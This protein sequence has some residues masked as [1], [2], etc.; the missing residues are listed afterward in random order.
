M[1]SFVAPDAW[2]AIDFISDLHLS[3]A[4]PRTFDAW[5][6]FMGGT[7]ADAVF[8]LGDLFE[9]WVGDDSRHDPFE[10]R[11]AQVL[12]DAARRRAVAF[13]AGNRDFLVGEAL[14]GEC[15]VAALPDPTLLVACGQRVVLT[16]GDA[17]CL[18]DRDY[19]RYRAQV[20]SPQWQRGVLALPLPQ[21]RELARRM[22]DA[23]TQAQRALAR[24]EWADV[25]PD[26]AVALLRE[27][28]AVE[29]VHG[30]THRPGSG[31]LAPGFTRHVLSDW[32]LDATPPRAQVLRLTGEGFVR[33]PWRHDAAS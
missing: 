31:L 21:R 23:T 6:A 17:L 26:A 16:H 12:A 24:D 15:R 14:L 28:G 11:C 1:N 5:A 32:D 25:D 7:D 33:L 20:R 22:R 2:G 4:Q 3:E 19:Q 9:A 13:M 29:M 27:A 10:A 8:I 30:H 18:A